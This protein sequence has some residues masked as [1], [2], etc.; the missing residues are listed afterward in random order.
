M[1]VLLENNTT[2]ARAPFNFYDSAYGNPDRMIP[3]FLSLYIIIN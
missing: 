3:P 1:Y 2:P